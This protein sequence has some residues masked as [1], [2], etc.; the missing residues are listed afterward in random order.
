MGYSCY[1]YN[2]PMILVPDMR[3]PGEDKF[4]I[5]MKCPSHGDKKS[6]EGAFCSVCGSKK[7]EYH[8]NTKIARSCY[9]ADENF[10]AEFGGEEEFCDNY[11]NITTEFLGCNY[12][13]HE[14]LYI[15]QEEFESIEI[16]QMS[17]CFGFHEQPVLDIHNTQK[18]RHLQSV[19]EKFNIQHE[20][21]IGLLVYRM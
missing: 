2:G 10:L 14:H 1:V 4:E 18:I 12:V 9:D 16:H 6:G 19:L 5:G 17:E 3:M 13:K 20:F 8:K 21:K 11:L 15:C 7:V